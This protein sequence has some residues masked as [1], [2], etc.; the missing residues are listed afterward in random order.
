M[1][2]TEALSIITVEIIR[3]DIES[4]KELF[5]NTSALKRELRYNSEP[6]NNRL[7]QSFKE[8]RTILQDVV[9]KFYWSYY[10]VRPYTRLDI[11]HLEE[12]VEANRE[13]LR[14]IEKLIKFVG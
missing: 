4:I 8:F 10:E 13:V 14:N 9:D 1:N 5:N 3:K 6:L 2:K 11:N 12:T 7:A